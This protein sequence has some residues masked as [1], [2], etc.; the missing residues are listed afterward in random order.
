MPR[1]RK[2]AIG[3]VSICGVLTLLVAGAFAYSQN[4]R[5]ASNPDSSQII[6]TANPPSKFAFA[7]APAAFPTPSECVASIGLACYTPQEIRTAYNVPSKYNGAGQ[8]IVIVDAYGSPTVQS[9]LHTFDQT[10]GL[11]DPTLNI[12][13][14]MGKPAYNPNQHHSETGWAEETSLDVQWSHAIAPAAT[15]DLVI[16][17]NNYG[18]AL[19]V[20]EQYAVS[21]HLGNVM[22]MSFGAPEGSIAG[23]GNNLQLQQAHAIYQQAQAEGM[24][25]FASSGD[26]GA[27]QGYTYANAGYPAS[28]PL[29][30]SVGGTN[31][32]MSDSG[33]YQSETV[34]NDGD[35]SLC[36]FGCAYGPFGATGGAPSQVFATPAFQQ[37]VN[38]MSMRTTSDVSYNASVYTSVLVYLGFLGGKNNGFYFFGGTS[39][40]APQWAAITT[41]ANQAAAEA[42]HGPVGYLNPKL[43]AIAQNATEYAADFHD[44]TVGNNAFNGPGF[45]AKAGYDLP[46]GLGSPNVANLIATLAG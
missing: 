17:P 34:W 8:T 36:P 30:T 19:N 43:Y 7:K 1:G 5:A 35:P 16:A 44:V 4:A 24:T 13:Y 42:G 39:E 22:S 3:A 37:G 6:Y 10:F 18:N 46:T 15:I 29:V 25:V 26:S 27:S 11:P 33:Q 41:L 21:H 40:G 20:A 9:D 38:G 14:P 32:F 45:D 31:L 28:D 23:G 2:I 12:I